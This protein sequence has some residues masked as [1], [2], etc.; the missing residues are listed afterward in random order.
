MTTTMPL[1][2]GTRIGP[3]EIVGQLGA[4][5]TG[6]VYRAT[7]TKLD[8]DVAIKTLPATLAQEPY[9]PARFDREAE[10]LAT[11]NHANIGATYGPDELE[12]LVPSN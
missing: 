9:R 4:G 12:R 7:D 2:E 11:P 1:S 5:G 3:N 6:E 10:L 8:R